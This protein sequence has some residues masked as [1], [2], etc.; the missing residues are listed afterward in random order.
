MINTVALL[1][2]YLSSSVAF[3]C[4]PPWETGPACR[5]SEAQLELLATK[6]EFAQLYAMRLCKDMVNFYE[7]VAVTFEE[8]F[9]EIDESPESVYSETTRARADTGPFVDGYYNLKVD[10]TL[11]RNIA[12]WSDVNCTEVV[13]NDDF[14]YGR[15]GVGK[16]RITI[17][18]KGK[19]KFGGVAKGARV[20]KKF[21]FNSDGT[22]EM[23]HIQ[24]SG[25]QSMKEIYNRAK[26]LAQ[27][28]LSGAV[29]LGIIEEQV[30][31]SERN[32]ELLTKLVFII[33]A[34]FCVVIAAVVAYGVKRCLS[35]YDK[36]RVKY[37]A[38]PQI[39]VE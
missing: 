37:D 32:I 11:A 34:L 33:L 29:L 9:G 2:I 1:F 5:L 6:K 16:A 38:V 18:V 22:V 20:F 8:A 12:P 7:N 17:R 27:T 24:S 4:E 31:G 25:G 36:K 26:G 21:F 19:V 14:K 35:N 30:E 10:A 3:E 15:H 28:T 23:V 13:Y 39:A